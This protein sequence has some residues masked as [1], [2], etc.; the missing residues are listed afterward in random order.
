MR[1]STSTSAPGLVSRYAGRIK[2]VLRYARGTADRKQT[3]EYARNVA[4]KCLSS[5]RSKAIEYCVALVVDAAQRGT[6]E[7]AE[8][9]GLEL[10][11]IARAEHAATHPAEPV[12]RLSLAE[13]HLQAERAEGEC[14]EAEAQMAHDPSVTNCLRYLAAS[15]RLTRAQR[16]LDDAARARVAG[17]CA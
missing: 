15:A 8:A 5:D 6:L 1:R 11:A 2:D 7:E 3:D 10:V 13:A 14:D 17:S 4:K 12:A 16:G 9:I